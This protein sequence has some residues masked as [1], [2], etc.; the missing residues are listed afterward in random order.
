MNGRHFPADGGHFQNGEGRNCILR[1]SFIFVDLFYMYIKTIINV[2]VT[3]NTFLQPPKFGQHERRGHYQKA[4]I[5]N[6]IIQPCSG[7]HN[8]TVNTVRGHQIHELKKKLNSRPR[9]TTSVHRWVNKG[10]DL[11]FVAPLAA[12]RPRESPSIY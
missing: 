12:G 8:Y 9:R 4:V 10:A 11:Q 6:V 5:A 1:H 3:C 7:C 2:C